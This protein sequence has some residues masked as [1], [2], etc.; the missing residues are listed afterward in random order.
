MLFFSSPIYSSFLL[1]V[2]FIKR[3]FL[4][5]HSSFNLQEPNILTWIRVL[6]HLKK[7][8]KEKK[9]QKKMI[10]YYFSGNRIKLCLAR[11]A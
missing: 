1:Y 6:Q 11:L 10:I 4:I 2:I 7:K 3:I 5:F 8:K 9:E